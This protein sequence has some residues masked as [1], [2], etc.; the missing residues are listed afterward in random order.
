M[1]RPIFYFIARDGSM[2][3]HW[4][5]CRDFMTYLW[6]CGDRA[7]RVHQFDK[8]LK[9]GHQLKDHSVHFGA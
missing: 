2:D 5:D 4:V 7:K 6:R 9:Q 3:I 8:V 1:S